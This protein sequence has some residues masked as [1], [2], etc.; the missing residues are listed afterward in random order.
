MNGAKS[1]RPQV[2]APQ[3]PRLQSTAVAEGHARC[4]QSTA[5]N[6]HPQFSTTAAADCQQRQSRAD[7][8]DCWKSC[9]S[10]RKRYTILPLTRD[11]KNT[12]RGERYN[13]PESDCCG[14]LC[15]I[16]TGCPWPRAAGGALCEERLQPRCTRDGRYPPGCSMATGTL[17]LSQRTERPFGERRVPCTSAHPTQPTVRRWEDALEPLVSSRNYLDFFFPFS[18]LNC[19]AHRRMW[20]IYL[21]LVASAQGQPLLNILLCS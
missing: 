12:G 21:Y 6:V 5:E 17:T 4:P 18:R 19:L 20:N 1:I 11:S 13:P 8:E 15:T 2:Q 9:P 14:I 10:T 7:A 16:C 3:C